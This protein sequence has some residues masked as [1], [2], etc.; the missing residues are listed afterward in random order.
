MQPPP[1]KGVGNRILQTPAG[2]VLHEACSGGSCFSRCWR[3]FGG[4]TTI[5]IQ[6]RGRL[7]TITCRHCLGRWSPHLWYWH[8]L[9]PSCQ[10]VLAS[11]PYRSMHRR[12]ACQNLR[13]L[14]LH[15][16][17]F[18]ELLHVSLISS[19]CFNF[20]SSRTG[21]PPLDNS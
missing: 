6:T 1:R 5:P 15:Q 13:E 7:L 8:Y 18:W 21:G 3:C 16:S 11:R 14:L 9:P 10:L 2:D 19:Q 12:P 4:S 20:R 17:Q